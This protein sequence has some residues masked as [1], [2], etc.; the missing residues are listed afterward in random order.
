MLEKHKFAILIACLFNQATPAKEALSVPYKLS[1]R[2]Y[3][4]YNKEMSFENICKL[5]NNELLI[6]ITQGKSLHRF[7]NKMSQNLYDNVHFIRDNYDGINHFFDANENE[8]LARLTSLKGIGMHKAIQAVIL[9]AAIDD[10]FIVSN[11]TLS[12]AY[13]EC[14]GIIMNIERDKDLILKV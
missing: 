2:Y 4:N 8:L 13:E 1:E 10:T 14:S 7:P 12:K 9:Y 3:Y 6:L 11:K 5:S